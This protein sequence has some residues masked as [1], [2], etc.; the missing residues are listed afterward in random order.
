MVSYI[1]STSLLFFSIVPEIVRDL[2]LQPDFQNGVINLDWSLTFRL[3]GIL[4][5]YDLERNSVLLTRNM[6]TSISLPQEPQGISTYVATR[7]HVHKGSSH[8][9]HTWNAQPLALSCS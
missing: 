5:H 1:I 6:A 2:N 4:R 9:V 8:H 3:N 7:R